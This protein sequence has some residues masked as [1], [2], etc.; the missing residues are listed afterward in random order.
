MFKNFDLQNI[1]TPVNLEAF[2]NLLFESKYDPAETEFLLDG[3][4]HGFSIG[5]KGPKEV[6]I[7]SPNLKFTGIGDETILW[8]KVMKEVK[9]ARY[10]GPFEQVPFEN[11]IQSLIWLVPKDGGKDTGL[12]FHLSY[13]R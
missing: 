10:V 7:T 12:I 1:K 13:P 9:E 3:F 8:N 11:F 4:E 2:R 5:Y 6:K